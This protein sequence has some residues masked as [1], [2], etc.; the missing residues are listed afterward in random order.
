MGALPRRDEQD[1]RDYNIVDERPYRPDAPSMCGAAPF[2]RPLWICGIP[3]QERDASVR[4]AV[5][6]L[7]SYFNAICIC[8][9]IVVLFVATINVLAC[10]QNPLVQLPLF[11]TLWLF[12]V[13][14][15]LVFEV[16]CGRCIP[17][18]VAP[19]WLHATSA[20]GVVCLAL[21]CASFVHIARAHGALVDASDDALGIHDDS[22][23]AAGGALDAMGSAVAAVVGEFTPATPDIRLAASFA[24]TCA[25]C[26]TLPV[27]ILRA[28][29]F[30]QK[31]NI[32]RV[33][34]HP[35]FEKA[36]AAFTRTGLV[37]AL[38]ATQARAWLVHS[39]PTVRTLAGTCA[40]LAISWHAAV[41][42]GFES[43]WRGLVPSTSLRN[44]VAL[45][46]YF[47]ANAALLLLGVSLRSWIIAPF[48]S[49]AL[50]CTLV[51]MPKSRV[52]AV[53]VLLPTALLLLTASVAYDGGI[54]DEMW[55]SA[56]TMLAPN[57]EDLRGALTLS[58]A[59][60]RRNNTTRDGLPW[61]LDVAAQHDGRMMLAGRR[62]VLLGTRL[63]LACAGVAALAASHLWLAFGT[64]A[65]DTGECSF[66]YRYILRESCSQFDSLPLT[67]LTIS[68]SRSPTQTAADT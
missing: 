6:A 38:D 30:G 65:F 4:G 56:L 57:P 60:L 50:I 46:A 64:T 41:E 8:I 28:V 34:N 5:T 22:A 43:V 25:I 62:A 12:F 35:G 52:W 42:G 67:Y 17:N 9:E 66:I 24:F 3:Y 59:R 68:P 7:L 36:L 47:A 53:A 51:V 32:D 58:A 13:H 2:I 44:T 31:A 15:A 48:A 21:A 10:P 49:A 40:S 1:C 14:C 26:F 61:L 45:F 19:L 63:L 55:L 23:A 27:T 11:A 20:F 37:Q 16:R 18:C 29:G 54:N 39:G 33:V